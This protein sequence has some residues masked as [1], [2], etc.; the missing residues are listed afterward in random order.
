VLKGHNKVPLKPSLLQAEQPQL[1]QPVLVGDMFH[2]SDRFCVRWR[3]TV[4]QIA[5]CSPWKGP[6]T[7]AGG[8][9]KEPVTPWGARAGEGSCQ[10]LWTSGERS[11]CRSR[12]A[13]RTCDPMGDP[14]WS[15]LFLKDC[16]PVGRNHAGAVC[17]ELQPMG[18]THVKQVC[19]ELSPVS[20]TS[21]WSRGRV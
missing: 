20:G 10:D 12:F 3:S 17:E 11:P 18:R 1:T 14:H 9:A 4:E 7:G 5:T 2:P 21:H 16:S 6:H 13:G 8:G 19:G 15:S